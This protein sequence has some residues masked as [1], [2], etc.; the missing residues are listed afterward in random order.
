MERLRTIAC[1]AAVLALASLA[2]QT[3]VP[4]GGSTPPAIRQELPTPNP[5]AEATVDV[6]PPAD[7]PFSPAASP[8]QAGEVLFQDDFADPDSG[9]GVYEDSQ[10]SAE[11][12]GGSFRIFVN[13]PDYVLW[14]TPGLEYADVLMEVN[15]T[16]T[17]GPD[18][19]DFGLICRYRDENNF[20]FLVVSSDGFYG[21]GKVKDGDL[22][23]V[24]SENMQYSQAIHQGETTNRL[25]A[26]CKGSTLSL[27][28][29]G[30]ELIEVQDPDL[31]SGDVGLIAGTFSVQGADILFDDLVITQP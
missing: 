5:Q 21:I 25:Q 4:G 10:G 26:V 18:E 2:C 11:Y 28:A 14:S 3:L 29:N 7:E 12:Q 13:Q 31:T 23:L 30:T 15:A 6:D 9:W 24:G 19:N 17:A 8:A 16:K 1:I 20:Y 22:V 27:T